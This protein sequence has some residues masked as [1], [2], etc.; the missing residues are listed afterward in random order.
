MN[1]AFRVSPEKDLSFRALII[2]Y[3]KVPKQLR[4]LFKEIWDK[5]YPETK[6]NDDEHL[7]ILSLKGETE[8]PDSISKKC[9][10][11]NFLSENFQSGM[12]DSIT[13]VSHFID[14][15]TDTR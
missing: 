3:N 6:W 9:Y 14:I 5:Q 8:E 1:N 7:T 13:I 10:E 4:I 12:L 15:T 11:E 2:K